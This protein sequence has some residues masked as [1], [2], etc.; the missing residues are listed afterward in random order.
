MI[1]DHRL[2]AVHLIHSLYGS[3]RFRGAIL[4]RG[5]PESFAIVR[6]RPSELAALLPEGAIAIER[7]AKES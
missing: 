7:P 5:D 4:H 2:Y 6:A 3:V 1:D